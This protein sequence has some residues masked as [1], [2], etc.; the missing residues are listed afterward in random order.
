MRD[1]NFAEKARQK[2]G[3]PPVDKHTSKS[4]FPP[5]GS[6]QYSSQMKDSK[7]K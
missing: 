7:K 3:L 6:K 4:Q 2:D 1:K 5:I